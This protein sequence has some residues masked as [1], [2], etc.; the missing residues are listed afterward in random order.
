M[1][2]ISLTADKRLS[3]G[4]SLQWI[5]QRFRLAPLMDKVG[6]QA[7][8]AAALPPTERMPPHCIPCP[9][10]FVEIPWETVRLQGACAHCLPRISEDEGCRIHCIPFPSIFVEIPWETVRHRRLQR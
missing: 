6:T 9:S 5:L 3:L 7:L 8:S 1:H 2:G 4:I 10:I